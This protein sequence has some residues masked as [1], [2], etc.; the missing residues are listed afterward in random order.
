MQPSQRT[1]YA[2]RIE[3]AIAL[4]QQELA[5]GKVPSLDQLAAAAALSPYHFHRIFRIM[6]GETVGAAI[7]RVRLGGSLPLLDQGISAATGQSGY[8]TSQ[9]YARALRESTSVAPSQLQ[10]DPHHRAKVAASLSRPA[11]EKDVDAPALEISIISLSPLRLSII[12]NVGDYQELNH[13][14][15]LLFER[16]LEH[17]APMTSLGFTAFPT[18]TRKKW[19]ART[20]ASIVG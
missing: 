17:M 3:R 7:K 20:A 15:N 11:I 12:R 6:T 16:L 19:T 5:I 1:R 14:F 10:N 13:G 8:A 4:L 9:A 18:M 2:D